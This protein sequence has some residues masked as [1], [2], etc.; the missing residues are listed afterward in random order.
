MYNGLKLFG[1]LSHGYSREPGATIQT[2]LLLNAALPTAHVHVAH[3]S[4]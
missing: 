2:R 3:S 4:E 1:P